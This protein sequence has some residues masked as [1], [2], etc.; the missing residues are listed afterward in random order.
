MAST[1]QVDTIKD[2]G[3]NTIISSNGSGTFTNSLPA[4]LTSATGTLA[5][6]NGGTGAATLAAAGLANTPSFYSYSTGALS[7][8]NS[9]N[10]NLSH[11]TSEGFDSNGTYDTSN[12]R[13]TPGL[14]GKYYV[15][16][17]TK[18]DD[19]TTRFQVILYKNGSLIPEAE[20]QIASENMGGGSGAYPNAVGAA[21]VNVTSITD[22]YQAYAWQN[23]GGSKNFYNSRFMA[24]K[25]IGA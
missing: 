20:G 4:N 10:T 7:I 12:Q 19:V 22:Y 23:S 3:G 2:I 1:I 24:F 15:Y 8:A 25:V 6:A 17:T 11:L 21:L 9:T 13:W 16:I 18:V 14:V 5:I